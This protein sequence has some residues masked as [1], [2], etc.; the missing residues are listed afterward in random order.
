MKIPK[1]FEHPDP[2][3]GALAGIAGGL[4]A[5]WVMN[6]FLAGAK[7]AQEATQ[8]PQEKQAT[9]QQPQGEDATGK[10]A[11]AVT[12]AVTG[13]PLS[14]EGKQTGGP[15]VHYAFGTLMG[16]VYGMVAE[17]AP[18]SRTGF[19]SAFGTALFLGADEVMV[20]ALGLGKNP[21]EEPAASQVQHWLAHIVYGV[22]VELVRR[23]VRRLV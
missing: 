17:Y 6:Q 2:A 19:G 5:S 16:G 21:T 10:V 1:L 14:P 3:R 18:A 13:Q 23:G 7:M 9:Q 4:L 11:G 15:V 20:P 8:S 12:Q 22:T